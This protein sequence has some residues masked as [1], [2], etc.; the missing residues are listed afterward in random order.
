M[1]L[2]THVATGTVADVPGGRGSSL[3]CGPP[4]SSPRRLPSHAYLPCDEILE[5]LNLFMGLWVLLQVPLCKE[6][7]VETGRAT[8][9]TAYPAPFLHT[10]CAPAP[11]D[12]AMRKTDPPPG[13]GPSPA[14][15][16]QG[17]IRSN[18]K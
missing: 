9:Y 14:L 16:A 3:R 17:L 6:G 5:L 12:R 15:R 11:R 7:L 13:D 8:Q 4:R 18:N 10:D 1:Y 2:G